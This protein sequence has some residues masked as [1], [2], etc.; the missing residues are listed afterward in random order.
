MTA[1]RRT[2]GLGELFCPSR[3][4]AIAL[5]AMVVV[6]LGAAL[7][8]RYFIIENVGFGLACDAG[9]SSFLCRLRSAAIY[10][11]NWNVFGG[12]AIASACFQLCRPN[13]V[14]FGFGLIF[15]AFG[16]VLYNTR[17]SALAVAL[18]ILSLARFPRAGMRTKAG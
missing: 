18:L 16:L 11:F 14:A 15:A 5:G 4:Q 12:M 2:E 7:Y 17:L 8:L 9:Q 6:V 13:I 3:G 1:G 10:L